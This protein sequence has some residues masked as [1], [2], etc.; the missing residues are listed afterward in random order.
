MATIKDYL[1]ADGHTED[2][3][4]TEEVAREYEKTKKRQKYIN[5]R[6]RQLNPIYIGGLNL[7]EEDIADPINRNPEEILIGQEDES[8]MLGWEERKNEL[9]FLDLTDTQRHI[10]VKYYIKRKSQS[11]IAK[12]EGLNRS[13]ISKII[14]RIQ[15]II[16]KSI[17]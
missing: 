5:W 8:I 2:I 16:V 10:A 15:K 6:E 3:E 17:R 13:S 4:A 14:K 9:A 12:E 1:F 11:E 7:E